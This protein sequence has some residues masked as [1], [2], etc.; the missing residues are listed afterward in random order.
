MGSGYLSNSMKY[1][2]FLIGEIDFCESHMP[3]GQFTDGGKMF[4]FPV[5][6]Q[7]NY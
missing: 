1:K 6:S 4:E 2:Y 5:L 7:N 3:N